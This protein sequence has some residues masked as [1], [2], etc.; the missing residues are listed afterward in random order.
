MPARSSERKP[1]PMKWVVLAIFVCI[2]PYT[3]ITLRYRKP[4]PAYQ[5]YEDNK[6]L[7]TVYRLRDAGFQRIR[8]SAEYAAEP[9]SPPAPDTRAVITER[10]GGLAQPLRETLVEQPLVPDSILAVIAAGTAVS[11][12]AYSIQFACEVPDNR[13]NLAEAEL[14]VH[15][16]EITIVPRFEESSGQRSTAARDGVI[17]I[18]VPAGKLKPGRY[19][20]TLVGARSS[21]GWTLDVR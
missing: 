3:W 5:P 2:I 9:P 6:N 17:R 15:S 16:G 11:T 10:P 20:V 4:G 1:W 18:T 7:A 8:A 21:Q 13:G 19:A 14:Y 12:E